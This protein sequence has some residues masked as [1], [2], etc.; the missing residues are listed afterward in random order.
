MHVHLATG[1]VVVK[2]CLRGV[3]INC[4][5]HAALLHQAAAAA[6]TVRRSVADRSRLP[7]LCASAVLLLHHL[8]C[9]SALI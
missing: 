2:P 6:A 1:F 5:L 7:I 9:L 4:V 3:I 8:I